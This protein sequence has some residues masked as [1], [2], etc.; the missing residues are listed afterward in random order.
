MTPQ[1]LK[2]VWTGTQI[3]AVSV[4]HFAQVNVSWETVQIPTKCSYNLW[5]IK[6]SK[7]SITKILVDISHVK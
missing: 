2:K 4:V 7:I 6:V 5:V 3:T 1:S